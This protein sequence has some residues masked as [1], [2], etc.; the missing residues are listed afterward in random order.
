MFCMPLF[1]ESVVSEIIVEGRVMEQ[2]K[3]FIRLGCEIHYRF[4]RVCEN[5][6][7]K[8]GYVCGIVKQNFK[9]KTRKDSVT[10]NVTCFY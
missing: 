9:H 7:N 10:V 4:Y 3:H 1:F 2:V 6:T 8:F 5:K